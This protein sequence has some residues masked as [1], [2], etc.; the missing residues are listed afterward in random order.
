[1]LV[2]SF[3]VRVWAQSPSVDAAA[4]AATDASADADADAGALA[5]ALTAPPPGKRVDLDLVRKGSRLL[6]D[7]D[8]VQR[9]GGLLPV[10]RRRRADAGADAA[11]VAASAGADASAPASA[12]DVAEAGLE[13]ARADDAGADDAGV[14]RAGA[15]TAEPDAAV[16]AEKGK[17]ATAG[18]AARGKGAFMAPKDVLPMNGIAQS[19]L[20]KL[21]VPLAAVPAAATVAAAGAIAVWPAILKVLTGLLKSFAAAFLKNREKKKAKIQ[22]RKTYDVLGMAIGPAELAAVAIAAIVYGLGAC[23]VFQGK[24]MQLGF[25]AQQEGLV[26][27][28]YFSRSIV[29]FVYQRVQ[30]LSTQYRF[31]IGGG[32]ICLVSAYLGTMLGTVGFEIEESKGPEDAKRLVNMKAWLLGIAFA[33]AVGFWLANLAAPG[34]LLQSGRMMLSGAALA[35]ILPF[36][37]MPGKKIFDSNKPLWVALFLLVVPGFYVMNF[38]K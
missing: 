31:W 36:T 19:P 11:A 8:L 21:G 26:L 32:V 15:A 13:D 12:A 10:I 23:Y 4:D 18:Q 22:S 20:A 6:D 30:K 29:R 28:L 33:M 7:K 5:P 3:S 38:M 16:P 34:K 27:G 24:K 35:E 14:D 1:M 37:P 2:A 17:T 25:V 9:G